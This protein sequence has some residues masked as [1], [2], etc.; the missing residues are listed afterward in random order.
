MSSS[1]DITS[2]LYAHGMILGQDIVGKPTTSSASS[3]TALAAWV[4][5]GC[6]NPNCKAKKCSTHNTANCYWPGGG[7][8]G[9]FPPNFGQRNRANV[10][11][12][13]IQPTVATNPVATSTSSQ[14]Q[15]FVLS[16]LILDT[17]GQSGVMIDTPIKDLLM[18]LI[19]KGFEGFVRGGVPTFMD[20]GASNIMFVSREAL[21]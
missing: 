18:A 11:S 21:E 6:T 19:S 4:N 5:D 13:T 16:A 17:P 10:A 12:T 3:N 1:A 7:K 20:S 2:T 9:Q 14:V 15:S 8:E